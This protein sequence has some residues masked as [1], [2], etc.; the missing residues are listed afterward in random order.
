MR[1]MD[2][3]IRKRFERINQSRTFRN[4]R[5]KFNLEHKSVLDVGCTYG[6]FLKHFGVGSKG[7]TIM[8]EEVRVARELGLNVDLVN[9]EQETNQTIGHHDVIFANNIFEHMQSPHN[10]LLKIKQYL[11]K[12]GILILGVPCIPTITPLLKFKK[13]RGA[14]ASLHINFFSRTALRKTVEYAGWKIIEIRGFR[15]ANPLIDCLL[16]PIY[17]HFYVIAEV[18]KNFQPSSK[19]M[20]ELE[21]Y[22]NI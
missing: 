12:D 21:G 11:R 13:F 3:S 9:I 1:A 2:D 16:N 4:I 17:P 6:E 5:R 8:P 14:L 18:D 22:R 10:F 15:F 7:L 20:K 19:R